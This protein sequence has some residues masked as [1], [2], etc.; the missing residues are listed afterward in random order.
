MSLPT[1]YIPP[2][3]ITGEEAVL[4]GDELRHARVTLRLGAG[5]QVRV[6]DGTGRSWDGKIL[7]MDRGKGV[8]TLSRKK[9]ES[10]PDFQLTVAMGIVQGERFDWAIQKG[11]ELGVTTFIPLVTERS[12]ARPGAR[13][14]RRDRL[15]RVVVSASK[16]CGRARFPELREPL[17]LEELDPASFD[18]AV[19]FWEELEGHDLRKTVEGI[20]PPSTCLLVIG[21][22]GGLTREEVDHLR[23]K[24]CLVAGLGPR[25]LRTET[26]VTA[27]AALFQFLWGDMK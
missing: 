3:D 21:P 17:L 8:L 18:L 25:I 22:V 20:A 5:G 12:G 14:K 15:W 19:V 26:A 27:C 24:G 2:A 13:W 7:S 6:V 9:T 11:T 23:E 4:T 1:F 10:S 16:Q